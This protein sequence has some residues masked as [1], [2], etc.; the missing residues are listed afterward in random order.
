MKLESFKAQTTE[1]FVAGNGV[2][3]TA[4]PWANCEGISVMI[5]GEGDGL[6]I[7][8]AFSLRWEELDALLVAVTAA[9]SS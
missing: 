3:V 2:S 6:P 7:R 5:H 9:R 8:A 4:T 1:V